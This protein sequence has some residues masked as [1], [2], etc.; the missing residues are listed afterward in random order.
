MLGY[1]GA[2]Q[3]QEFQDIFGTADNECPV[4]T[5]RGG[6]RSP[7]CGH[8]DA[9]KKSLELERDPVMLAYAA[10]DITMLRV[11]Y[12]HF[13]CQPDFAALAHDMALVPW[14]SAIRMIGVHIDEQARDVAKS[15]YQA[16]RAE[17]VEHCVRL[18]L[19]NINSS[20]QVIDFLNLHVVK[21][22]NTALTTED[23]IEDV[24][25]GRRKDTLEPLLKKLKGDRK[26][27]I[28]KNPGNT[29]LD[30]PILNLEMLIQARV[31]DRKLQF[32]DSIRGDS[33]F[34]LFHI[35]GTQTDRM[36]CTNPNSQQMPSPD[37][38]TDWEKDQEVHFRAMFTPPAGWKMCCG[39]FDQ[40]ELR[41]KSGITQDP[42]T[43]AIYSKETDNDP[44][45][46]HS[47]TALKLFNKELH[48][49]LPNSTDEEILTLLK[50]KDKRVKHF[51][52]KAK[53]IGFG[54]PYGASK[55]G[56]AR[57]ADCTENEAEKM[58]DDY[59]KLCPV[60]KR[61][62]ESVH[63]AVTTIQ[64]DPNFVGILVETPNAT[65]VPNKV[66]VARHF[67]VALRLA[68]IAG[69][70]ADSTRGFD[71][72]TYLD[73]HFPALVYSPA[74]V[75][76]GKDFETGMAATVPVLKAL[77]SA[78]RGGAFGLQGSIQRQSFNFLIQSLGSF[79]TK[80]LQ[81]RLYNQLIEPGVH[82]G[83]TLP[84][85]F[86]LQVHDEIHYF[87][88]SDET[89][90]AVDHLTT[91]FL[92]QNSSLVGCQIRFRFSSIFSWAEK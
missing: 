24:E 4:W 5:E 67:R 70:I 59:W 11:V 40:L 86:G 82:A 60:T 55:F 23:E 18:G 27:I 53:P 37:R 57:N 31:F 17:G 52:A 68:F 77:R 22:A 90:S 47:E 6:S 35:S 20:D 1:T 58:L 30:V 48:E 25:D 39:D 61:A 50:S 21:E 16:R 62:I 73:R 2:V 9:W 38:E 80:E 89:M 76:R 19:K 10:A 92:K 87:Y 56:I 79:L 54:I 72:L 42:F 43:Q 46:E 81:S 29:G 13:S 12:D 15:A 32:V 26:K 33:V 71:G 66:G 63:S 49:L 36:T 84:I 69:K 85:L 44:A 64:N 28:A 88:R 8:I 75:Y 78:L 65:S 34:P 41:I 83:A 51:R 14:A 45:D 91:E 7:E 74:V 3:R